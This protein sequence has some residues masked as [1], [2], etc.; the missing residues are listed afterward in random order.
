MIHCGCRNFI[1]KV[2]ENS[3]IIVSFNISKSA[4]RRDRIA[5]FIWTYQ[6][7]QELWH[8]NVTATCGPKQLNYTGTGGI[9]RDSTDIFLPV[10]EDCSLSR[11]LGW[12]R[13]SVGYL[14]GLLNR[15]NE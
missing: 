2:V 4:S 11:E 14:G 5:T 12:E 9:A 1:I 3:C 6:P 15:S 7:V 8:N 13:L 10:S